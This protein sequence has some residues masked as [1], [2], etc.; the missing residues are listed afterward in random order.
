MIT[1]LLCFLLC[2]I[3]VLGQTN[4]K[5]LADSLLKT[6]RKYLKEG[7]FKVA[8]N[9]LE[10]SLTIY[11]NLGNNKFIG[12]C[13]SKIATT[14]YY[15]GEFSN[16]LS[17]YTK[18]I[19]YFK[20]SNFLKGVASSLNN[21]GAIYYYLGNYSKALD[22]YKKALNIQDGL[23]NK[24][25]IAFATQNIGGIYL[26]L[27]DLHNAKRNFLLA[28]EV[29][30]EKKEMKSLSKVLNSIG[31]VNLKEKNY[32]EALSNF[33]KSLKISR[34]KNEKQVQIEV[35]FNLGKLYELQ[36]NYQKS[37][38]NYR[39]S[40]KLS[41]EINNNL[42]ESSNLIALGNIDLKLN[43][44]F[45]AIKKC[46]RGLEIAKKI[47]AISIQEEA[48]KCLYDAYKTTN[49][50]FAALKYNEQMHVLKDSLNL[51]Q[52]SD[53]ILNMQ[54][55]KE[56]LLDS[57]AHVEKERKAELL[58]QKIVQKKESQRNIFMLIGCFAFLSAIGIFSRLR[59]VKKSKARL[60]VE[61]DRSEHLLH[62]ILPEEVAEELKQ[63]GYVDA[64][65]FDKASIL[66]TD[67]KS[68]TET[69]SHL[70]PQELVEEI[71][72]C[73]KAFDEIIE[74]YQIEK[75]KTIGD[76]YMAA[77]GLPKP[78]ADAVKKTI[79][80]AIDMQN[81]IVK[82]KQENIIHNKPAFDMRVGIHV[83]PIIA[84]IV[85]VKKFQ[86]DVWGDTVNI[87]SRMESNGEVGKVNISSNTYELVKQ[88]PNL[89]F[90]Y[91]GKITAK[92]KG[93]LKMYF[94][95]LEDKI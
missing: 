13:Y 20:K 33:K 41:K 60:Q 25:Q 90:E 36:K 88:E 47:N 80:A 18:S 69:A 2:N 66:F 43:K 21:T 91:R 40:L 82:R 31:D 39:T 23:N 46:K 29:Y 28:K 76:A 4:Q 3:P 92:G 67:F 52:T 59:F 44:K 5:N 32:D 61:K 78:D 50:L 63:K 6:S 75:I 94:V 85:G 12:N 86:Y 51:K 57:I 11:K 79:L 70:T 89:T 1:I 14:Y 26:E 35:L 95:M 83:G 62:N 68:F 22:Y 73:F 84:G 10:K 34:S 65:D 77:G 81:F 45:E 7:D 30:S 93:E 64:Q 27:N 74:Y 48:C 54:F 17:N 72:I 37:L 9:H 58:H 8:R 87:A 42:Y 53:K 15:Q 56:M 55:E 19:E 24:L 71:N 49:N 38:I 16:A